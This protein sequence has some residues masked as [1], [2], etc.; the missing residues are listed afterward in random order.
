MLKKQAGVCAICGNAPKTKRLGV[1]HCHKTTRVRGLLCDLCNRG[2]AMFR[3]KPDLF[4]KA[5]KYVET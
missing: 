2:L 3:D 1:D 4:I 5:A